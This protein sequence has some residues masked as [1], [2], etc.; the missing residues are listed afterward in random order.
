MAAWFGA[1]LAVW[2]LIGHGPTATAAAQDEVRAARPART[3]DAYVPAATKAGQYFYYTCEF[4]AAWVILKTFGHDVPF[5]EQLAI[6]GYDESVEPT[7]RETEDGFVI[8]GG[9]ITSA[10]SGDYTGNLFARTTGEA[11]TPL[12]EEFG[13]DAS[14]VRTR[15][16]IEAALDRGALIWSKATVDFLPWEPATWVTPDGEEIG[17]VVGNDHAVV[18]IGYDDE[19]VVV[20]DVLGP[21]NTN[22][23]R[24][25]E[26]EVP[27]TTY[28]EVLE[29]QARDALAVAPASPAGEKA[30]ADEP[31]LAP[32]EVE[33]ST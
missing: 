20:R 6:V 27:W 16:E 13:L 8:D 15:G 12:F 11:M 30:P 28:L 33:R 26:Y 9:D 19:V 31:P 4:D 3:Y 14:P 7:L 18:L 10:F 5:E 17:G 1:L 32:I 2:G 22:W 23:E 25:D 24:A 29:A 21:T